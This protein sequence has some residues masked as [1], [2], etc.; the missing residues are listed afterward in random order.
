M[1]YNSIPENIEFFDNI[2]SLCSKIIFP[3]RNIYDNYAKYIDLNKYSGKIYITSHN[4]KLINHNLLYIP[5]IINMQIN[6]AFVGN[7]VDYKGSA[8]FKNIIKEFTSYKDNNIKYH[9]YG[10]ISESDND[11][12]HYENVIVHNSYKDDNIINTLHNDSIH[13]IIHLSQFEESYCYALT[14]SINSGLPIIYLDRGAFKERLG[15]KDK[16]FGKDIDEINNALI[17]AL[18][19]IILNKGSNYYYNTNNNIQ[20]TRW[21]LEN[22]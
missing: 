3:S 17:A 2:L 10:Y 19:Y 5:E 1:F 4:D 18:D 9:I 7:F 11:I 8:L 6:I 22:Y 13:G 14:N 20:P 15:I 12:Y 21:Y 16:Y